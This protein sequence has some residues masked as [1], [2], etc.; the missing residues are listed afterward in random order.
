MVALPSRFLY[1]KLLLHFMHRECG[2]VSLIQRSLWLDVCFIR[3]KFIIKIHV[4]ID[5]IRLG[6]QNM[7]TMTD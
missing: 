7:M 2:C 4:V 6:E 1:R 3:T 5:L